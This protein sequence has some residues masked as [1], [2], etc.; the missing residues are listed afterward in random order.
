MLAMAA[1][2]AALIGYNI[3]THGVALQGPADP[4]SNFDARPEWYFRPLF[5][6]LKYF[7]G[8][9]EHVIALGTPVVV[10]AVLLGLPFTDR[11]PDRSPRARVA[12]LSVLG[13]GVAAVVVLTVI[14][15]RE[16]AR[17]PKLQERLA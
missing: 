10:G 11:G 9:L 4:A 13:L 17:D 15:F 6:L 2:F 8:P 3:Y 1:V 16:D 5:Q 14:S 7:E 12:F